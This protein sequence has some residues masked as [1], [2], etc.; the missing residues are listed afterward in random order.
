MRRIRQTCMQSNIIASDV[1]LTCPPFALPPDSMA[2]PARGV[3]A[4]IWDH[5]TTR[6]PRPSTISCPGTSGEP[7]LVGAPCQ[8][9]QHG[10]DCRTKAVPNE[11]ARALDILPASNMWSTV[12]RTVRTLV[13][14]R[15]S[16]SHALPGAHAG[17]MGRHKSRGL[18][19]A[20]AHTR[21]RQ[22]APPRS[23]TAAHLP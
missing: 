5:G 14:V 2:P 7:V 1:P 23:V 15:R 22:R 4:C 10:L 6:L 20:S 17:S 3:W 19:T 13:C 12:S 21:A 16:H 8:R 11:A 18:G 9:G